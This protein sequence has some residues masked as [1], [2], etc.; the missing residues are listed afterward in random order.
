MFC[1]KTFYKCQRSFLRCQI[2]SFRFPS[3]FYKWQNQ[4]QPPNLTLKHPSHRLHHHL[5]CF[6]HLH[7]HQ[8]LHQNLLHLLHL[9]HHLHYHQLHYHHQIRFKF[10]F[11]FF[12][13]HTLNT[14]CPNHRVDFGR[15][16]AQFSYIILYIIYITCFFFFFIVKV[17][18]FVF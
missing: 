3:T 13:K 16:A 17:C 5:F 2:D 6:F 4:S 10:I 14:P 8:Q 15:I 18:C 7:H 9:L 11:P 1:Q 12:F